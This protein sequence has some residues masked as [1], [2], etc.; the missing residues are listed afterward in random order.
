MS[1]ILRT[2]GVN[3][4]GFIAQASPSGSCCSSCGSL[5]SA[6]LSRC[7]RNAVAE[8]PKEWPTPSRSNRNSPPRRSSTRRSSTRPTPRRR[9]SINEARAS[10]DSLAERRQQDAIA[11]AER[12]VARAREATMLEHD[13][14]LN[15]VK[16]E[17]GRLVID[18]TVQGDRQNSKRRRPA[19]PDRRNCP[20]GGLIYTYTISPSLPSVT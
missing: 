6:R 9:S 7:L 13:R 5:P 19:P 2:F 12:I 17:L 4:P 14:V 11:E 10:S 18:T 16:R 3:W 1:E 20:S 15:D 8:S